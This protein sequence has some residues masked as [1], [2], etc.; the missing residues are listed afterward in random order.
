MDVATVGLGDQLVRP[1]EEVGLV[2]DPIVERDPGVHGR[3]GEGG[4][5]AEGEE[6]LLDAFLGQGRLL[7][8][9]EDRPQDAGALAWSRAREGLFGGLAV[10]HAQHLRLVDGA[11]HRALVEDVAEVD[12]RAGHG[13][14]RDAVD[15]CDVGGAQGAA[16]V[17]LDPRSRP[18]GAGGNGDV[19]LGA[20]I[21]AEPVKSGPRSVGQLGLGSAGEH[22]GHTGRAG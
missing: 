3:G 5:S 17:N 18:D 8:G 13:G 19:G 15:G 16:L 2:G 7:V 9:T 22:G 1:P 6:A 14:A 4:S 20:A 11:L 21:T 10:E 12:E